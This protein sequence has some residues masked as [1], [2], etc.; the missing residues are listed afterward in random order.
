MF[1]RFWIKQR[2][3]WFYKWCLIFYLSRDTFSN[4]RLHLKVTYNLS[5]NQKF[6]L[7][8]TFVEVI[9][10]YAQSFSKW[11][12]NYR[13]IGWN[14]KKCRKQDFHK[15]DFNSLII[16][17]KVMIWN[18]L[19]IPITYISNRSYTNSMKIQNKKIDHLWI[20]YRILKIYNFFYHFYLWNF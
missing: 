4:I 11:R 5:I 20:K 9:F 13:K 12:K 3:Y 15:I 10:L 2:V 1:F 8:S 19:Y 6:H 14:D 17:T 16:M 7:V 18:S